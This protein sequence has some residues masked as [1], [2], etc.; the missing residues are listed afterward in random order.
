[1]IETDYQGFNLVAYRGKVYGLALALGPVDLPYL[2]AQ[3]LHGYE[4]RGQC[5]VGESLEEVKQRITAN[6]PPAS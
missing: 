2:D 1:L 6:L 5:F 4:E 3:T